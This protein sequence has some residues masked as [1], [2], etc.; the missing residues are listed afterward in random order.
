LVYH[1]P[2]YAPFQV[3]FVD[4]Y[5]TGQHSS[6]EGDETYLIA[7]CDM[8]GFAVMKPVKHTTSS[9][10]ALALLKVQLRFGLAISLCLIRAGNF[11]AYSKRN[12]IFFS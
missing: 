8:M 6:F 9:T 1:I 3:V 10:I 7:C 12:A 11:T 4:A 5:S 2:I